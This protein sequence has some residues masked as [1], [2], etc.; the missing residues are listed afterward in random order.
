MRQ[1]SGTLLFNN[2][3]EKTGKRDIFTVKTEGGVPDNLTNTPDADDFDPAWNHEGTKIAFVSDRG[4][5]ED[6]RH[7][8]DIWVLDFAHPGPPIQLTTNGSW[9]DCPVWDPSG[10]HI[11][12]RSNRGGE[13]A[14]WRI[15][16][17]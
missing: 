3:N 5:D 7:N 9:D 11:Y 1:D 6:Q 12:F 10:T 14:I 16:V 4:V 2:V 13:W 17:K 8:F 15:T